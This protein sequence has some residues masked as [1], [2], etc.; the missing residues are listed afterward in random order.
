M[1]P[2]RAQDHSNVLTP[3]NNQLDNSRNIKPDIS[4]KRLQFS[5]TKHS[6]T[7]TLYP[8]IPHQSFGNS[9]MKP[10]LPIEPKVSVKRAFEEVEKSP[11]QAEIHCKKNNAVYKRSFHIPE[12]NSTANTGLTGIFSIVGLDDVKTAPI[13]QQYSERMGPKQSSP[14]AVAKNLFSDLEDQGEGMAVLKADTNLSSPTSPGNARSIRRSLS[15]DSDSSAHE[16]SLV[17]NTPQ[18]STD[19]KHEALSSSFEELN[20][21]EISVVTP[22]A[23]PTIATPKHCSS[24]HDKGESKRSLLDHPHGLSDSMIKSPGFLK[25]KNVVAFRS[26]CSSIN[27]SCTSHLSLASLDAMEMSA[28]TSFHNAQSAV[29]PVQKKRPSLNSSLY[30]VRRSLLE[31]FCNS[32][33]TEENDLS[34]N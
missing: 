33:K 2:A 19:F 34:W 10:E 17:A 3:L 15:L 1:F 22:A 9:F 13:C 23:R 31:S 16:M 25:P 20:E 7:P 24:K 28:S 11:E 18:K 29:T 30:Q 5:A 8:A 32:K 27:R 6:A 26:Y 14:I 21:N 12:G 4:A